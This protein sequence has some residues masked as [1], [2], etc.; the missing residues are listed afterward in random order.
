MGT[1]SSKGSIFRES[2]VKLFEIKFKSYIISRNQNCLL[3][4][5]TLFNIFYIHKRIIRNLI[6]SL[7][8]PWVRGKSDLKLFSL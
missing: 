6:K 8:Y 3:S 5:R 1:I 4:D 7:E 2:F